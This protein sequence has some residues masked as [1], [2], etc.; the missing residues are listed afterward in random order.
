MHDS[1]R[2]RGG[3]PSS[4]EFSLWFHRA[5]E[6]DRAAFQTLLGL[7]RP[8]LLSLANSRLNTT[9]QVKVAP[10]DVVQNTVWNATR[11]FQPENFPN[12]AMLLAWLVKILDNEAALVRRKFVRSKN[13]DVRREVSLNGLLGERILKQ[14]SVSLSAS[15]LGVEQLTLDVGLLQRALAQLPK[16]YQLALRLRYLDGLSF[17]VTAELLGR[18][19][20]GARMLCQRALQQLK[21]EMNKMRSNGEEPS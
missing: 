18:S 12:R 16:H 15:Q 7:Y 19:Y 17:A 6:G 8:L 2:T 10:S 5:I 3:R 21:A 9:L 1:K 20:D 11:N 13:R 14:L 4:S